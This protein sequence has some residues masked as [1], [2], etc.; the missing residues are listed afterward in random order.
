MPIDVENTRGKL[1]MLEERL[2]VI[3]GKISFEFGD[4]VGLCLV[5]DVVILPKFK[6]LEFEKYKGISCPKSHITMYCRKM[7][8]Y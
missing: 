6:V 5:P 4:V 7:A 8:H 1:E 3:E 2:R